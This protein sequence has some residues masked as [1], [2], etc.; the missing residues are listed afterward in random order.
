MKNIIMTLTVA[1][2]A[3]LLLP[4]CATVKKQPPAVEAPVSREAQLEAQKQQALPAKPLFK[5]KVAIGRFSNETRYGRSLLR[6]FKWTFLKS[7]LNPIHAM[8]WWRYHSQRRAALIR[9]TDAFLDTLAQ[10]EKALD[11]FHS[12]ICGKP[13]IPAKR[14]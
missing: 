9:G 6:G 3:T 2:T 4:G 13:P 14:S 8:K 11:T 5:R 7:G 12:E 10:G 1:G